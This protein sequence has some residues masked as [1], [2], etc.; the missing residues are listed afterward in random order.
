DPTEGW[1][2]ALLATLAAFGSATQDIAVD[3]YRV[4]ALEPRHQGAM[5]ASYV[6]GYRV[7]LLA[8]GAGALH[9]AAIGSWSLAYVAMALLMV[10][11][12]LTTLIVAEP[13]QH[14]SEKTQQMEERVASY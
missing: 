4:E 10:V 8:A 1:W 11:G 2:I 13:E 6:T 3:A 5:A 14:V 9:I 7:A 12:M